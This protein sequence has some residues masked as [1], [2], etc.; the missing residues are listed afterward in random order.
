[1][2]KQYKIT[3]ADFARMK[4]VHKKKKYNDNSFHFYLSFNMRVLF[5]IIIA[6]ELGF[7]S[8]QCFLKGDTFDRSVI[9]EYDK[10]SSSNYEYVFGVDGNL[11][12]VNT[13]FIYNYKLDENVDYKYDNN[14]KGH[15]TV[16]SAL[17]NRIL[18][19]ED[20]V[21]V[22][23]VQNEKKSNVLDIN[24]MYLIN[25]NVYR[26]IMNATSFE[27]NEAV[28]AKLDL[29]MNINVSYRYDNF[30]E[31][32]NFSD[33]VSAELII[34]DNISFISEPMEDTNAYIE[35]KEP[36]TREQV[37]AYLGTVFMIIDVVFILSVI[38]F[39]V[40]TLPKKSK[41]TILRDGILADYNKIIVNSKKMPKTNGLNIID[42]YSFHEL[43]D[44]QKLLEKPIV[45]YEIVN[46]QKC[47]FIIID[48]NDA[49]R[50]VLKKCDVEY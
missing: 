19:E 10:S 17:D 26:D 41:Y 33:V 21:L 27:F 9:L 1:M 50:F 30:T 49:Y 14:L 31:D 16:Y 28:Y 24:Q 11:N 20:Y 29:D 15:F 13:K 40:K 34:K 36:T 22:E 6:I 12:G 37:L 8:Y 35:H 39:V 44:A 38:N 43:L 48:D 45:Y 23:T 18:K 2:K 25:Y 4:R 3:D 32:T 5:A 46:G 47:V 42:C 7:L